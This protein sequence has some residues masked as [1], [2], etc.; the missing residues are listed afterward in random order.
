[1]V[2]RIF[3]YSYALLAL[4]EAHNLGPALTKAFQ[5]VSKRIQQSPAVSLRSFRTELPPPQASLAHG[6]KPII[7][8]SDKGAYGSGPE[9]IDIPYIDDIVDTQL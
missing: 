6:D 4:S 9:F 2:I 8:Y 3:K 1:M 5:G 7:W